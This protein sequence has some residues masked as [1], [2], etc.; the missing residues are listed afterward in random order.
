[1]RNTSIMRSKDYYLIAGSVIISLLFHFGIFLFLIDTKVLNLRAFEEVIYSRFEIETVSHESVKL[2]QLY[3]EYDS[4]EDVSALKTPPEQILEDMPYTEMESQMP[5]I[6]TDSTTKLEMPTSDETKS[7]IQKEMFETVE[8]LSP[9]VMKLFKDIERKT[10]K[11]D[12]IEQAKTVEGKKIAIKELEI[13][14]DLYNLLQMNNM[15]V[16]QKLIHKKPEKKEVINLASTPI[17]KLTPEMTEA[18]IPLLNVKRDLETKA[19]EEEFIAIYKDKYEDLSTEVE[20]KFTNFSYPGKEEGY[21]KITI[22]PKEGTSLPVI[23]KDVLF[24]ID[25]SS[26]IQDSDIEEVKD[27]LSNYLKIL[28]KDD[29]FNVIVFSDISN[30]L[31]TDFQEVNKGNINAAIPFINFINLT[32]E[33]Y[34]TN[35]YDVLTK[36]VISIPISTRPCNIFFVS[37]GK[38]TAGMTDIRTIVEDLALARYPY[39]SIFPLDIGGTGNKYFLDLLAFESRGVSWAKKDAN[40]AIINSEEFMSNYKDPILLNLKVNYCNL[41][42][43]KIYPKILPNLYK[44]QKIEIYGMCKVNE[45]V[46]LR[47]AGNNTMSKTR[48]LFITKTIQKQGNGGPEIAHE[49]ARRKAHYLVTQIAKKGRKSELIMEIEKL[50]TEFPVDIPYKIVYGKYWFVKLFKW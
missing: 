38:P 47:I 42:E 30:Q 19:P 36:T 24:V 2:E 48:E 29:R 15:D 25:V 41:E 6:K 45:D 18:K 16:S 49:W 50:R 3:K 23:S 43:G 7:Q 1:M 21:F 44:G 34:L 4:A 37:D 8:P 9:K 11:E 35:V 28:N 27:A 32:A 12:I 5:V 13:F 14:P 26:S 40:S 20:V 31:F 10:F 39:I 17:S 22:I 46:A 33:S